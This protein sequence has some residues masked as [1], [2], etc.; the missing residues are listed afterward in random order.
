MGK[1]KPTLSHHLDQ[2]TKAEFVAQVPAD[3]KNED[4][5]VEVP[6]RKQLFH[7]PQLAHRRHSLDHEATV[8]ETRSLFTPEPP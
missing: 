4:F 7:A 8:L 2:I 3:T 6:T 1:S 5:A